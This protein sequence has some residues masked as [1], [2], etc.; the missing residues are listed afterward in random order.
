MLHPLFHRPPA[1]HCPVPRRHT[2]RA[3]TSAL[4]GLA[5]LVAPPLARAVDA[6][7]VIT[8]GT[9]GA[10]GIYYA[11]GG[12]ICH[13]IN[14]ERERFRKRCAVE[15]TNASV[16]NIQGLKDGRLT[17]GL[18]QS[19]VQYDAR[20]GLG[21]FRKAGPDG[22]LRAVLSLYP[23][24]LTLVARQGIEAHGIEDFRQHPFS[25]GNPGSGTR[26]AMDTLMAAY[27][28]KSSHFSNVFEL[29][30]DE[31]GATLCDGRIDGFVF[32]TLR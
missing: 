20:K 23:E 6:N 24:P 21:P 18:A 28:L 2:L 8:I 7:P 19:D 13:L 26:S 25:I 29:K 1:T 17:L 15:T 32:S 4:L 12:A 3:A 16:S 9:G 22:K 11:T 27:R 10:T 30:A 14:K 5:L 31:H